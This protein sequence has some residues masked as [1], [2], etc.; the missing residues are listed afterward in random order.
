MGK[1]DGYLEPI[2]VGKGELTVS[3]GAAGSELVTVLSGEFGKKIL[4][5]FEKLSTDKK[6][7]WASMG[8]G[9]LMGVVALANPVGAPIGGAIGLVLYYYKE[10]KIKL[11]P[12]QMN[13]VEKIKETMKGAKNALS[14]EEAKI[15][16][17]TLKNL[18]DLWSKE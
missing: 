12:P 9:S 18:Q 14:S 10:G 7:E 3:K 1:S 6:R 4:V 17:T 13:V 2:S 5:E 16:L 15:L 11:D 8:L